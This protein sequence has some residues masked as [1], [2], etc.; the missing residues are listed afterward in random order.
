MFSKHNRAC[1]MTR[2]MPTLRA[3][4]GAGPFKAAGTSKEDV[5]QVVVQELTRLRTP[6]QVPLLHD[7]L[8]QEHQVEVAGCCWLLLLDQQTP[9]SRCRPAQ[10]NSTASSGA[11]GPGTLAS[12][13]R[14][15]TGASPQPTWLH[16]CRQ[17][18]EGRG[19]AGSR[20]CLGQKL[21]LSLA[22]VHVLVEALLEA[23]ADGPSVIG[24]CSC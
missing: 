16:R 9:G 4:F 11:A 13:A 8:L 21:P 19:T 20:N 7:L 22:L 15:G 6:L 3:C 24:T 5:M 17:K 14:P 2:P 10:Q 12:A 23:C 1:T 18:P